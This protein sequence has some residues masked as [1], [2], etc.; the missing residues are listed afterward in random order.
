MARMTLKLAKIICFAM[1]ALLFMSGCV[2]AVPLFVPSVTLAPVPTES[3]A[4][5]PSATP[6]P[7]QTAVLTPT[8]TSEPQ[9][10]IGVY[11]ALGAFVS[12]PEHYRQY[13]EF[14]NIQ[15][16]E[17]FGDTFVDAV[18]VNTYPQ[19]LVCAAD[20]VFYEG[21]ETVASGKLQTQDGQYV[22]ILQ[23]G[24]NTIYAQVNTDM[25][26][27]LMEFVFQYDDG[28]GVWPQ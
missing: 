22:L 26:L 23:P 16:Y 3:I 27:T 13:L 25:S 11:D 15:V 2:S 10:L 4:P 5:T 18:A 24:E 7:Q 6:T 8:P 12:M 1:V 20:I 14:K 19:P 9:R 17:Q 21:E 28:L